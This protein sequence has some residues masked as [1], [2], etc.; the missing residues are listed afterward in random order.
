MGCLPSKAATCVDLD[1]STL[2]M[3]YDIVDVGV[4]YNPQNIEHLDITHVNDEHSLVHVTHPVASLVI[5]NC[6]RLGYTQPRIQFGGWM[7]VK[8][9]T[10]SACVRV[11]MVHSDVYSRTRPI[12]ET[13][14][15]GAR[16]DG[17]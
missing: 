11:L 16:S 12:Y 5:S 3:D 9:S 14:R 10:I 13:V 17:W 1:S 2:K 7:V 4:D 6:A 8:N 15:Y